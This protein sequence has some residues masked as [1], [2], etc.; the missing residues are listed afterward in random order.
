[1]RGKA[2]YKITMNDGQVL[3]ADEISREGSFIAIK[4]SSNNPIWVKEWD[5]KKIETSDNSMVGTAIGG[6][7]LFALTGIYM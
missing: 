3:K 7:I 2:M 6:L 4:K 5:I 1:M